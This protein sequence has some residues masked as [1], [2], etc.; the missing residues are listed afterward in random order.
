MIERIISI[1]RHISKWL[2]QLDEWLESRIKPDTVDTKYVDLAPTDKADQ[3]GVYSNALLYATKNSRVLNIAL[4]GPYG[5][6]KSSII[7]SFL[8]KYRRPALHI[9]LAAFI[10]ELE[11]EVKVKRQD[12]ERSILQQMLYGADAKKLPLS[13]FKRIQSPGFSAKFKTLYILSGIAGGVYLFNQSQVIMDGSFFKPFSIDNIYNLAIFPYTIIFV[14]IVLHQFY[15]ASF[16]LSL[17]SISLKD[18]EIKPANDDQASILNLHLDEIIYFF[19]KTRYDLVVIEDIDRFEDSDIFVTL[20]EINSLVNNN[21]GVKRTIRFLYAL[22]DDIFINTDRTKFFEFIIP[23]IPIINTNNSIDMVLQQG[24][25]LGVSEQLDPEFLRE[26][27][28]YLNDLRLIQNIFNEYEIYSANLQTDGEK[29]L[30]DNKLLA[31]LIYKNVYPRD[32]EEL[33][34]GKG[35]LASILAFQDQLVQ[36]VKAECR[37]EISIYEKQ[38]EES[39]SQ[40]PSDLQELRQIYAMAIIEKIP[41]N[42]THIL[43][44]NGTPIPLKKLSTNDNF[45]KI[46]ETTNLNCRIN[47]NNARITIDIKDVQKGVDAKKSYQDRKKEIEMKSEDKRARDSTRVRELKSR[48]STLRTSKLHELLQLYTDDLSEIFRC[49][50]KNG[51]LA[52]FL[53][54]EGHLDDTYYQYTSLF[55]SGRLSPNDNKFLIQIRAFSTPAPDFAIDNPKEVIAAMRENDFTQKYVLNIKIVDTLLSDEHYYRSQIASLFKLISSR[56]TDCEEFL[57]EYYINGQGMV[58]LISGIVNESKG[59][60]TT[61][62][63][64][65][66]S[67]SHI[68]NF[69][70][71]LPLKLLEELAEDYLVL[72]EFVS[73]NLVE[74]LEQQPELDPNRL[75]CLNFEVKDLTEISNNHDIV[76]S[77]FNKGLF[78]LTISNLEYIYVNILGKPDIKDFYERNYTS[79]L[80]TGND[81]LISRVEKNFNNYLC[82]ILNELEG[83]A[84]EHTS[85]II[86]IINKD[87][88]NQDALY[89]FLGRQT[90]KL[91]SLKEIPE[92]F[93]TILFKLSLI[94]A[95]WDNCFSYLTYSNFDKDTLTSYLENNDNR[96]SIINNK[97]PADLDSYVLREFIFEATSLSN[98]AYSEY[99]HILPRKFSQVPKECSQ[100]KI[101][102][103]IRE[104]KL[105]LNQSVFDSLET[106]EIQ[107]LLI[108]QYIKEY[109]DNTDSIN[110]DDKVLETLLVAEIDVSFKLKLIED[111]DLD[112]FLDSSERTKVIEEIISDADM[113]ILNFDG[114][115]LI[116]IL[117]ESESTKSQIQILNKCHAMI[118]TDEIIDFLRSLPTPYS[119]L[120]T[121][122][123]THRLPMSVEN[124][125]LVKWLKLRN[126]ISSWKEE[127][128]PAD[129]IKINLRRKRS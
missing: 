85:S 61:A 2:E 98:E 113:S 104:K 24:N 29:I 90:V 30:D 8:R 41:D 95:K 65:Q 28:R 82:D 59:V 102:I 56:F 79:I 66:N 27:S 11:S 116:K 110:I 125:E 67:I 122:L 48:I 64:S 15:I 127:N 99:I 111:I 114:D 21:A 126:I 51:E 49:F 80:S 81:V 84:Y 1:V 13:R 123:R 63:A 78:R 50:G 83:N 86:S 39:E 108:Q 74:I 36:Q 60:I 40:V 62:V 14:W 5:S 96:Q 87:N 129:T 17:K 77:M 22:R 20:R 58:S 31:V 3:D 12:I 73:E 19:Q 92:E 106:I 75:S 10:P 45:E 119:D 100:D 97:I 18:V 43:L 124:L 101:K 35:A 94:E 89:T 4:T 38:I 103:L 16:G 32:F 69:I 118:H 72:S 25:R 46:I 37:D 47:S 54:L 42:A 7:K 70:A 107:A 128:N 71:N 23:V 52:R 88:L 33:H 112:N 91:S 121:N 9:S 34:R 44:T 120:M 57:E 55:H 26:V 76:K 105:E 68:A 115:I 6:G 117:N 109:L 93:Y 53:I